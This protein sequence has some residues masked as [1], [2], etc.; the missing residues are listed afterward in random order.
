MTAAMLRVVGHDLPGMKCGEHTNVHLGVQR[1]QE[2]ID[3]VRGD[4]E[5]AVFEIPIEVVSKP[6]LGIDYRGPYVHGK[7]G[8][9]FCISVGV[10]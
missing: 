10:T 5:T 9:D 6:D 4:A 8:A 3:I 7:R 2:V 1:R